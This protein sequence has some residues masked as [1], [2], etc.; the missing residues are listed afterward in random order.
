MHIYQDKIKPSRTPG[1]RSGIDDFDII[2]CGVNRSGAKGESGKSAD[3]ASNRSDSPRPILSFDLK[4]L[5]RERSIARGER[6]GLSANESY[7]L[8]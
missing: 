4:R 8:A 2:R 3:Q 5:R 7:G 6:R 1:R